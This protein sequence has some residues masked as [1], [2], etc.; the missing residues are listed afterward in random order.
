MCKHILINNFQLSDLQTIGRFAAMTS[1]QDGFGAILR[2]KAQGIETLKSLSEGQFYVELT[3]RLLRGDIQTVV[4]H[5]RT[6]TNEPGID[7]AHPF[8]FQGNY[9][10][11][12][13]VVDVPGEHETKTKNDSEALLHHLIKSEWETDTIQGYF[14]C[15]VVNQVQTFVLVDALAPIWKSGRVYS[16]HK[17]TDDAER[18]TLKLIE[19]DLEGNTSERPIEVTE[20]RYGFDSAYLSLG[21]NPHELPERDDLPAMYSEEDSNVDMFLGYLTRREEDWLFKSAQRGEL[22]DAIRELAWEYHLEVT[23]RDVRELQNYFA[24]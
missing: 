8:E 15:F 1:D 21:W 23:E 11:H 2:T 10:T 22:L 14:S 5:H 20:S 24:A 17:M 3:Q 9:L 7:Y 19:I 18:I 12:N 13:G 16:S 4:V 6:S